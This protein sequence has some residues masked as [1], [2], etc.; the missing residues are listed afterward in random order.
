[1]TCPVD[2]DL[3]AL[4]NGDTWIFDF[5]FKD[6]AGAAI[7][8][9]GQ[10]LVYQMKL[11]KSTP[12][13]DDGSGIDSTDLFASVTFPSDASSVAGEGQ[14][15]IAKTETTG[16]TIGRNYYFEFRLLNGGQRFTV[17]K[18]QVQVV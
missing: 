6:N 2:Q 4:D 5:L 13:S 17:G 1:M 14:M 7:D 15:V 16:V 11:N 18:G 12:D 8:I 10:E 3:C 9:S